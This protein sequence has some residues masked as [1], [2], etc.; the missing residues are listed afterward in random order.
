MPDFV[1]FPHVYT[2]VPL[3]LLRLFDFHA[4]D[5]S[6]KSMSGNGWSMT[7]NGRNGI[8]CLMGFLNFKI[9]PV[10]SG[11]GGDG[12]VEISDIGDIGGVCM[13]Y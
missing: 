11:E 9:K 2:Y 5:A 8:D 6:S 10:F 4:S 3:A 1:D 12:I 13:V 7:G